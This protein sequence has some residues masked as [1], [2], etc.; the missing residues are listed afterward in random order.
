MKKKRMSLEYCTDFCH[1]TILKGIIEYQCTY[2]NLNGGI[3]FHVAIIHTYS[4]LPDTL[5]RPLNGSL[6]VDVLF[7]A[8][9]VRRRHLRLI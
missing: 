6:S 2:K 5:N 3:K 8:I 1:L 9:S 7:G 4:K